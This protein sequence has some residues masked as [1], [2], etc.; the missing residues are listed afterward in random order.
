MQNVRAFALL[1][2]LLMMGGCAGQPTDAEQQATPT[3][4]EAVEEN[5]EAPVEETAETTSEVSEAPSAEAEQAAPEASEAEQTKG[6]QADA[7]HPKIEIV[8]ENGGV[9]RA[10]LYPE[11]APKT[12]EN[13]LKLVGDEFYDGLIFH[14]VIPDFMIQGGD[15]DGTGM[16]GP[17]WT[18][19]GEFANNGHDNPLLHERGVLSMA[20]SA[21]PNSAGSQFFIM[22]KTSPF[23]DGDYAAFGKVLDEESM[24][25]VDEI[26]NAPRDEMDKPNED[27]KMKTVRVVED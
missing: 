11:I 4:T 25:V 9:I 3:Q 13:F 2:G 6:I 16:G 10:E 15:P 20:R 14:R 7:V 1:M 24:K 27:Q 23:L 26:V 22:T 19:P 18:I 8:M 21:D 17:A 12:V 5:S